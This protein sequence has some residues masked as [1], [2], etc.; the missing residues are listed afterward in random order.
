MRVILVYKSG[1]N[2]TMIFVEP[3]NSVWVHNKHRHQCLALPGY[4]TDSDSN[5]NEYISNHESSFRPKIRRFV[6]WL[7][8]RHENDNFC[9]MKNWWIGCS[10]FYYNGWKDKFYPTGLPQRLWFEFYCQYFNTVELNVTFYRFPRIKDLETWYERSPDEFR[11]TVKAPRLITHFKKFLNAKREIGDFYNIV[12]KGLH[13]KLGTVL[14]QLHP[15]T[16]YSEQMLE[17]ILTTLDLSFNNVLEFRHSSWWQPHVVKA[18]RQNNITFCGISYPDLPD[19][20]VKS[21]PVV[22]YRF[23]GVPELYR[24]SYRKAELTRIA[25]DIKKYRSVTDV[26]CYFNNDIEVAAVSNAQTLQ[27]LVAR[28]SSRMLAEIKQ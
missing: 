11:F 21:S 22:Y 23:H 24:S 28:D 8:L 17:R 2:E 10:G 1:S 26:Y 16:E 25:E 20:A 18:L 14:F 4:E 27:N 7:L 5:S 9:S 6:E 19:D 3:M 12:S 13:D 15:R